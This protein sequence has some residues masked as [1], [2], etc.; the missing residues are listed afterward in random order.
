MV[1]KIVEKEFGKP[2]EEVYDYFEEKPLASASLAQVH[3]AH[4]KGA[5]PGEF[6]AVKVQ[7]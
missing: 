6:V 7:H 1:R 3:K 2:L 4:I 5:P